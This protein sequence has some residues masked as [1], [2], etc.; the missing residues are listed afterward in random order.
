MGTTCA[1]LAKDWQ[2]IDLAKTQII[3]GSRESKKFVLMQE[4]SENN[5]QEQ[6]IE[7]IAPS[8]CARN[9]WFKKLQKAKKRDFEETNLVPDPSSFG[10][11]VS[12]AVS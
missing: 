1:T 8:V 4:C 10:M 7:F 9:T 5:S 12:A 3:Q 6:E 11:A 2:R